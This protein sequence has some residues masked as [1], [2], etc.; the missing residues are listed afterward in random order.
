MRE[1]LYEFASLTQWLGSVLIVSA[2]I[3]KISKRAAYIRILGIYGAGSALFQFAQEL[4]TGK[5]INKVGDGFT[6]FEA[7]CLLTLYYV[8]IPL[9][10][11]RYIILSL[12]IGYILFFF[13]TEF[14]F[15]PQSQSLIRTARDLLLIFS[16]VMF[17][18][19]LL[20]EMPEDD[21]LK[22][23]VFWI[24]SAILFYFS[25]TFVLSIFL[26]YIMTV[27]EN[28]MFDLWAL[29]NLFRFSFCLVLVYACFLELK[30]LNRKQAQ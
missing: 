11:Y 10:S 29:R 2:S 18:Y 17:F 6:F 14:F 27:M 8:V 22:Y 19:Y 20:Q 26:T 21:V 23:P 4:V 7:L 28:K 13:T 3:F 30:N 5:M 24:N 15:E 9:K 12:G 1:F 16:P 25:G